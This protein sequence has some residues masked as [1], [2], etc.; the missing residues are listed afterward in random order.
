MKPPEKID[1]LAFLNFEGLSVARAETSTA[2]PIRSMVL[3]AG[4]K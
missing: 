4:I 3:Q 1:W 2:Q